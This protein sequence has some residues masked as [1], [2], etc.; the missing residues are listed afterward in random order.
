MEEKVLKELSKLLSI[1]FWFGGKA[2]YPWEHPLNKVKNC[3]CIT[4]DG[5]VTYKFKVCANGK[6][7]CMV[8]RDRSFLDLKIKPLQTITVDDLR[9]RITLGG[10]DRYATPVMQMTSPVPVK[11][12]LKAWNYLQRAKAKAL[13]ARISTT[14]L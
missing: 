7:R 12:D 3:L 10:K 9:N 6:L 8:I 11:V 14:T 13:K 4:L 5:C 2:I 1:K